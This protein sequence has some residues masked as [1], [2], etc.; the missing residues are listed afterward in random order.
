[1]LDAAS[2]NCIGIQLESIPFKNIRNPSGL[3]LSPLPS[4]K[5]AWGG[6][7]AQASPTPAAGSTVD[8]RVMELARPYLT[9]NAE[10]DEDIIRF[11]EAK[12][13]LMAQMA[14]G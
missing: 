13:K 8:P 14:K 7:P 6:S 4:I 11:Y 3:S 12:A 2:R 10:A 9:G 5:Q 1:M